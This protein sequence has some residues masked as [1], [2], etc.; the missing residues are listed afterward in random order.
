MSATHTS[1]GHRLTVYV[2]KPLYR[3]LK[4]E[5]G[6]RKATLGQ[7]VRERLEQG[8]RQITALDILG[9]LVGSLKGGPS[10]LSSNDKYLEGLGDD[11]AR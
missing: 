1:N 4:A 11:T 7:V 6:H 8:Q 10:D 9:D 3:R 2:P 5:A